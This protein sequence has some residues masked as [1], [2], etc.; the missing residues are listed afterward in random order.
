[1]NNPDDPNPQFPDKPCEHPNAVDIGT[2]YQGCC[3]KY[4]CPDCGKTFLVECPD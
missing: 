3:D 2:C 4:R 1:M